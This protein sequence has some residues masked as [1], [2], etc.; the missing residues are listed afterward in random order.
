MYV[1][2]ILL[3]TLVVVGLIIYRYIIKLARYAHSLRA[4]PLTNKKTFDHKN[5]IF[6]E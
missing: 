6:T 1:P 3:F 4:M 2:F 5:N